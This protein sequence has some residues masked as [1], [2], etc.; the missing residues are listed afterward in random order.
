[1]IV[2]NTLNIRNNRFNLTELFNQSNF[3]TLNLK[4]TTN[5]NFDL[6]INIPNLSDF[7]IELFNLA[8]TTSKGVSLEVSRN[9]DS[10]DLL[11]I[12]TPT[13]SA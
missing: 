6:S 5:L 10:N 9:N 7:N 8:R 13:R 2:E 1:M 3:F 12:Y 11:L 4:D